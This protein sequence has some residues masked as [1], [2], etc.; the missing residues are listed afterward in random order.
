VLFVGPAGHALFPEFVDLSP[1]SN[2]LLSAPLGGGE[3]PALV[4]PSLPG[5][6]LFTPDGLTSVFHQRTASGPRLFASATDGGGALRDLSGPA[7]SSFSGLELTADGSSAVYASDLDEA[8]VSELY[9]SF[10][11]RYRRSPPP[12]TR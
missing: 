2:P 11:V 6:V 4:A 5:L 9:Q 1:E 12:A 7:H 10:L 8:G 3:P